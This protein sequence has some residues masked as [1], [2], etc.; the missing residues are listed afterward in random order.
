MKQSKLLTKIYQ[1]CLSHDVKEIAK[2]RRLE[3]EKIFK[4]KQGG[5]LFSSRWTVVKL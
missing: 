1:A 2:L 4:R 5:K 3:F